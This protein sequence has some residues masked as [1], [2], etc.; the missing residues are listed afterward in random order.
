MRE[1]LRRAAPEPRRE[2]TVSTAYRAACVAAAVPRLPPVGGASG[3]QA[4]HQLVAGDEGGAA[5]VLESLLPTVAASMRDRRRQFDAERILKR[6]AMRNERIAALFRLAAAD[7]TNALYKRKMASE[8]RAGAPLLSWSQPFLRVY[9]F[10]SLLRHTC[11]CMNRHI[12]FNHI[13]FT[14]DT[15]HSEA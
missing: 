4:G 15:T 1:R 10:I 8:Y 5:D 2:A 14:G 9:S 3:R 7:P 6:E 12:P 11:R 13:P